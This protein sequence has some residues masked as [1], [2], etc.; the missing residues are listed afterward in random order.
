M[1]TI[2]IFLFLCLPVSA[3]EVMSIRPASD[4]NGL[5]V[6]IEVNGQAG[7]YRFRDQKDIDLNLAE[8]MTKLE[9]QPAEVIIEKSADVIKMEEFISQHPAAKIADL[10]TFVTTEKAILLEKE[11]IIE[12][13]PTK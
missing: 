3:F 6:I 2:A 10:E 4:K 13:V 8:R 12:E 9:A 11:A 5:D 7:I 1:K